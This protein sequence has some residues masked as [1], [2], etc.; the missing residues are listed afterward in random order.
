MAGDAIF[1]A[2]LLLAVLLATVK[3][4]GTYMARAARGRPLGLTRIGA[5][6]EA[7]IY[8][9][10]RVD[11]NAGMDWKTYAL[12]TLL[13][14]ALGL[15]ALY[16]L[17][18]IQAVLPLN[19]QH[20]PNVAADS[21]FNTAVSFVTNTSWQGYGGETT[22]S[23]LSQMLGITVQSFLSAASGIAVALALVRALAC[24]GMATIGNAWVDITRST[25]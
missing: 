23:H 1:Q 22:M 15:L 4:L 5:P 20:L 14:N 8:R 11:P 3:P 24:H 13:F 19:P 2:G 25:L 12:A 6:L 21:A 18:R 7:G 16:L 9:L 10:A 17:Q